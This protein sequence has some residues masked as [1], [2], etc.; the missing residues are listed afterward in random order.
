MGC[1]NERSNNFVAAPPST[2]VQWD[3]LG[4]V[5]G[6]W[7]GGGIAKIFKYLAIVVFG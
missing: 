5:F 4:W 2:P 7:V 1:D 3:R 6:G